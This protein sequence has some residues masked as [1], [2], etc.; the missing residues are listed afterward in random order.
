[1]TRHDL[2]QASAGGIPP[3][4]TEP[5]VSIVTIAADGIATSLMGDQLDCAKSHRNGLAASSTA[6][7][8]GGDAIADSGRRLKSP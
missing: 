7:P 8:L 6:L 5:R 4:A 3:P 2:V 1:M